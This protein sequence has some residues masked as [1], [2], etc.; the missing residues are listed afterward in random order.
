[1]SLNFTRQVQTALVSFHLIGNL[2]V[3]TSYVITFNFYYLSRR[4]CYCS[5]DC[6]YF[7][8]GIVNFF[9]CCYEVLTSNANK[10]VFYS[11]T[12]LSHIIK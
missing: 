4:F 8:R 2:K 6:S 5:S 12:N 3:K 11:I 1:M 10:K 7:C 9:G